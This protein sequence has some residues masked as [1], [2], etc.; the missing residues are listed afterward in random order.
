MMLTKYYFQFDSKQKAGMNQS[1]EIDRMFWNDHSRT[2]DSARIEFCSKETDAAK[3]S[4]QKLSDLPL[5]GMVLITIMFWCFQPLTFI[6]VRVEGTKAP[7]L[8]A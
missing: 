6:V 4:M 5:M 7:F 8:S 3:D 2:F 1:D